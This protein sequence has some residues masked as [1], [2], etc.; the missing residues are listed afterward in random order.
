[1]TTQL[2]SKLGFNCNLTPKSSLKHDFEL[3]E[4]ISKI[5]SDFIFTAKLISKLKFNCDSDLN[6]ILELD[7]NLCFGNK[8]QNYIQTAL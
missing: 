3:S 1:M 6:L 2:I 5:D 7:F 8:F 4:Q